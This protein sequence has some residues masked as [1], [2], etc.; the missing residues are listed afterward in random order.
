ML[1]KA[2]FLLLIF[3]MSISVSAKGKWNLGVGSTFGYN[4]SELYIWDYSVEKTF[5]SGFYVKIGYEWTLFKNFGIGVFP[6][7]QQHYDEVGI[8]SINVEIFS[9]NFDL[10]VEI[11]YH[12]YKD[13]SVYAGVSLQDYRVIEEFALERSYNAR[14]N[15]NLGLSYY[16]FNPHWSMEL[17]FSTILSDQRDAFLLRNYPNHLIVGMRYR[18]NLKKGQDDE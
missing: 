5:S 13:W 8:N 17:G 6:G 1:K 7:F 11:Y 9:Y 14:L 10:P 12:F 15:L 4:P 2:I 3:C 16:C 18:F